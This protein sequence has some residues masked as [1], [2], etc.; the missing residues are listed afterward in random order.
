LNFWKRGVEALTGKRTERGGLTGLWDSTR[1]SDSAR[2]RTREQDK[3][4]I[5]GCLTGKRAI[6]EDSTI[7]SVRTRGQYEEL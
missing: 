6:Q 5:Q 7:S 2:G 1:S 4:T 3:G